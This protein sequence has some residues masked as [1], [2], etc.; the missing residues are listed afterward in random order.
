MRATDRLGFNFLFEEPVR[1]TGCGRE[2][3]ET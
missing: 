3:G 1:V 2:R